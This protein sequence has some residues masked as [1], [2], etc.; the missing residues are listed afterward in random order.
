M[1]CIGNNKKAIH[2][3]FERLIAFLRKTRADNEIARV[4]APRINDNVLGK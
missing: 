1:S 3:D 2:Y 4:I